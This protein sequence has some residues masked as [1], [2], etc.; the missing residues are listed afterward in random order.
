MH[1]VGVFEEL[2]DQMT[3]WLPESGESPD[4]MAGMVWGRHDCPHGTRARDRLL[5]GAQL[6]RTAARLIAGDSAEHPFGPRPDTGSSSKLPWLRLGTVILLRQARERSCRMNRPGFATA[7]AAIGLAGP[8]AVSLTCPP[9]ASSRQPVRAVNLATSLVPSQQTRTFEITG[10]ASCHPPLT[11]DPMPSLAEACDY[12]RVSYNDNGAQEVREGTI[13]TGV[14]T[15]QDTYV[16]RDLPLPEQVYEVRVY[17]VEVGT[18]TESFKKKPVKCSIDVPILGAFGA[19]RY[20]MPNIIGWNWTKI[21][22]PPCGKT[23]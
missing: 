1:H 12:V 19:S 14:G 7:L 15:Y 11:V 21:F 5:L 18:N 9:A 20:E 6:H 13:E 4:R 3:T 8:L 23:P 17:H 10:N 2:E 16:V 22:P